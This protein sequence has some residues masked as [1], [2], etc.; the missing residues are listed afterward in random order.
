VTFSYGSSPEAAWA[1][2]PHPYRPAMPLD[3]IAIIKTGIDV[4]KA[5]RDFK[6]KAETHDRRLQDDVTRA[7]RTLYFTPTGI[8][9]LLREVA[10]GKKLTETRIQ[11]ALSDFNDREWKVEAALRRVDF[12]A[13]HR[14]LGLSLASIRVL[15]QLQRGKIDLRRAVQSEVNFYDQETTSPNRARARKLIAA[16]EDLNSKIEEVEGVVNGRA[17]SGPVRK[18]RSAKK[19]APAK[20]TPAA[21]KKPSRKTAG[22][23]RRAAVS[24]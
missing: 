18:A 24:N 14:E 10:A 11:K 19:R 15:D 21:Q 13:L 3:L 20:K 2:F 17:R 12:H 4:A 5:L 22:R 23:S 1:R 6:P 9:S 7:L 8:L 16:I